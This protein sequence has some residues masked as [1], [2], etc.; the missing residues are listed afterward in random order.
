[1]TERASK[2]EDNLL[3]RSLQGSP[4]R[5]VPPHLLRLY[6]PGQPVAR[7]RRIIRILS[8]TLDPER[9]ED[10]VAL[11]LSH[12]HQDSLQ[13][14]SDEIHLLATCHRLLRAHL[15]PGSQRAPAPPQ[16]Q[17]ASLPEIRS[18]VLPGPEET[19]FS[20]EHLRR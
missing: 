19:C 4:E 11:F 3:D 2:F 17:E 8:D 7:M 1:M 10:T 15:A 20:N 16:G 12:T 6:A 14:T 18:Y 9:M 5:E 13:Y